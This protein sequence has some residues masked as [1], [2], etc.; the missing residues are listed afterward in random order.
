MHLEV[1]QEVCEAC[2][3]E[4]GTNTEENCKLFSTDLCALLVM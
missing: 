3:Q 1:D 2:D 4:A